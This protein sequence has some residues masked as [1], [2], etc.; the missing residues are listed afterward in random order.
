[1]TNDNNLLLLLE[2]FVVISLVLCLFATLDEIKR[3]LLLIIPII[4]IDIISRVFNLTSK[5]WTRGHELRDI[6]N[7]CLL[8]SS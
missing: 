7:L 4:G 1:M 6:L 8:L 3:T 2:L 5:D